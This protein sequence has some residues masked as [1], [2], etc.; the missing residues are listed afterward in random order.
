ME[1][2]LTFAAKHPVLTVILAL[3]AAW[4]LT[5]PFRKLAWSY[6]RHLRSKNIRAHGWPKPP[7]DA[8]GDINATDEPDET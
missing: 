8:D 2:L 5:S 7:V 3:I 1:K 4:T 6:N